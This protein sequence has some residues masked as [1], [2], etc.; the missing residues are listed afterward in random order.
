MEQFTTREYTRV[1]MEYGRANK[2]AR[3]A[4]R[5]YAERYPELR[6]PSWATIL[7]CVQRSEETGF[8]LPNRE[9]P[10]RRHVHLHVRIEERI[11][12]EFERNPG[13]SVRRVAAALGICKHTVHR[14]LRENGLHPYHYRRVQQ[15]LPRN[16]EQ[17]IW[18]CEGIFIIFI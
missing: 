16:A 15:L 14:T 4:A 13:T 8:I 7:R 10:G 12:R 3:L 5:L 2:N 1:I 6:H 11:L 17:R 18:F 9:R